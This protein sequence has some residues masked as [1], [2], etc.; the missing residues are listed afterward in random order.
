MTESK[1]FC[2]ACGVEITRRNRCTNSFTI[3]VPVPKYG[4]CYIDY[5]YPDVCDACGKKVYNF[6]TG[7][8]NGELKE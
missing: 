3:G 5:I 2:D 6:L 8:S 7:K 1:T 4:G